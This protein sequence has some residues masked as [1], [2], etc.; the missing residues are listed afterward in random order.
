MKLSKGK[1]CNIDEIVH[2]EIHDAKE[3]FT[4]GEL[5]NCLIVSRLSSFATLPF[6][7]AHS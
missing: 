3:A 5:V 2:F 7:P 4:F 6:V 1:Q